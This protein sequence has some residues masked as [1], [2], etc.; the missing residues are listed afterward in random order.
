MS[1]LFFREDSGASETKI[2][3]F[4]PIPL[5][6]RRWT[7]KQTEDCNSALSKR[8]ITT[9]TVNNAGYAVVPVLGGLSLIIGGVLA[10]YIDR[11]DLLLDEHVP[12][13]VLVRYTSA[14]TY[15]LKKRPHWIFLVSTVIF[16]PLMVVSCVW[17]S[18]AVV[19]LL[20]EDDDL[21][22]SVAAKLAEQL[23]LFGLCTAACT[24][25]VAASPMGNTFGQILHLVFAG[26]VAS[27]GINY[28]VRASQIASDRG[29]QVMAT[30]RTVFWMAAAVGSV[31]MIFSLGGTLY[32]SY[33]LLQHEMY[34]RKLS[35]NSVINET[36]REDN[37][38]EV[39]N[40]QTAN[41]SADSQAGQDT[42]NPTLTSKQ[43][44]IARCWESTLALGQILVAFSIG[45]TL[46]TAVAEVGDV[47]EFDDALIPGLVS[48]A[49]SLL[50]F[51]LAYVLNDKFYICCQKDKEEESS[52][53]E[54]E[55]QQTTS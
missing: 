4:H 26:G 15:D 35:V 8:N 33:Q 2:S 6:Y 40:E 32:A 3:F 38:D 53:N 43:I 50:V 27:M 34:S 29:D 22:G 46:M 54:E 18:S 42:T 45:L 13:P 21:Q 47:T 11:L 24:V 9:M 39:E 5:K 14:A 1:F 10:L 20:Q 41:N 44:V 28:T 23:K 51:G 36:E 37:L 7:L 48:A 19:L 31:L 55:E 16:A 25:A 49:L 12:R 30:T 17:Q 52:N